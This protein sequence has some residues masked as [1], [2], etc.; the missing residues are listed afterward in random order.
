MERWKIRL[1]QNDKTINYTVPPYKSPTINKRDST[2][3]L[4]GVREAPKCILHLQLLH[5]YESMQLVTE[6][7]YINYTL[8]AAILKNQFIRNIHTNQ[9]HFLDNGF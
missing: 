7:D 6:T 9:C 3:C 4:E 5:N 1:K 2:S 8:N